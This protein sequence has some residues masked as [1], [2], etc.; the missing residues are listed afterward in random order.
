MY[1]RL[2]VQQQSYKYEIGLA[3]SIPRAE[4][5]TNMRYLHLVLVFAVLILLGQQIVCMTIGRRD[6]IKVTQMMKEKAI[7]CKRCRIMKPKERTS[8]NNREVKDLRAIILA[9]LWARKIKLARI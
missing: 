6:W 5:Q 1:E 3:I 7:R 4:S 2:Y 8:I 9:G